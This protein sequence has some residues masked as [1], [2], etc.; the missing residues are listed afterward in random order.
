M[1]NRGDLIE[2]ARFASPESR[3]E[4]D[5]DLVAEL[6]AE[7]KS[8]PSQEVEA[9]LLARDVACVRADDTTWGRFYISD[10][11]MTENGFRVQA[12]SSVFGGDYHRHGPTVS[13]SEMETRT[14]PPSLSG[15]HTHAI[16]AE[17]GYSES[18]VADLEGRGIIAQTDR[19][20]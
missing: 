9:L 16:M 14:G 7:M 1:L 10:P 6:A 3:K 17:I 4:H 12:H 11:Q 19:W 18:E 8:R 15:E 20:A 13:F 5:A 2:D